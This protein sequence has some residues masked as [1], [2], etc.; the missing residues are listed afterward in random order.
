MSSCLLASIVAPLFV[1]TYQAQ[2]MRSF[3][4]ALTAFVHETIEKADS[5]LSLVNEEPAS[6]N[7]D[8]PSG[9]IRLKHIRLTCYTS[10]VWLSQLPCSQVDSYNL[11]TIFSLED[12]LYL[13][14][15]TDDKPVDGL[16]VVQ[17][18]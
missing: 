8:P 6:E 17:L 14:Q 11:L 4:E 1:E 7:S 18:S 9:S 16:P 15:S 12:L 10:V 13:P 2:V 5:T 3:W